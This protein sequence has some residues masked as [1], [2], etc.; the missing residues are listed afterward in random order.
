MGNISIFQWW[1]KVK[2]GDIETMTAIY[3]SSGLFGS[4]V[5]SKS[6]VYNT[7]TGRWSHLC[8]KPTPIYTPVQKSD[9]NYS[10]YRIHFI[11]LLQAVDNNIFYRLCQKVSYAY[12]IIDQII[13]GFSP[14]E[15][16]SHLHICDHLIVTFGIWGLYWGF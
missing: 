8:S 15:V 1:R 3:G 5:S 9:L 10:Y 16:T 6:I 14:N 13:N 12:K 11:R 2:I 7:Y 4:R